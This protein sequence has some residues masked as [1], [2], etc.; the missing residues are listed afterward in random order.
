MPEV[1]GAGVPGGV[2]VVA[3]ADLVLDADGLE[4]HGSA[5]G[6]V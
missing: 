5:G 3:G 4:K 1:P 6:E 2:D